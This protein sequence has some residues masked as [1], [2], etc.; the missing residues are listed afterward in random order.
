MLFLYFR[1]TFQCINNWKKFNWSAAWRRVQPAETYTFHYQP[2]GRSS[3]ELYVSLISSLFRNSLI[4]LS[5]ERVQWKT[6]R[7]LIYVPVAN[8]RF[9]ERQLRR[10]LVH[11]EHVAMKSCEKASNHIVSILQVDTWRWWSSFVMNNYPNS[12][13]VR[14][15]RTR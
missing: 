14:S 6:F 8:A 11:Q 4:Y 1:K 13:V 9:V 5:P 12:A 2:I 15:P 3:T 10:L 7:T